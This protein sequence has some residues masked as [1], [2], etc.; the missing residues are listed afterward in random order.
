[1]VYPYELFHVPG[2][3]TIEK[4]WELR[5]RGTGI[6]IILGNQDDFEGIMDTMESNDLYSPEELVEKSIQIDPIAWL[7]QKQ[8]LDREYYDIETGEWPTDVYPINSLSSYFDVRTGQPYSEA[9]VTILPCTESWQ[10][11][12]YLCFGSWNGIPE[13]EEHA[14]LLRYWCKKYEATVVS[15]TQDTIELIVKRPPNT[16]SDAMKLAK[17]HY[18]YCNDRVDQGSGSLEALAL[19]LLDAPVWYFWWD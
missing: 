16:K 11:P 14:A 6:P 3:K 1:M 10:A 12:C 18:I 2:K 17:Q 4:L 5:A 15:M 19:N 9:I 13:P 8:E 7:L